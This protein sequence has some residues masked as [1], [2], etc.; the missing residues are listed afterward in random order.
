MG[1]AWN[2]SMTFV[3][4]IFFMGVTRCHSP[5]YVFSKYLGSFFR[6]YLA[7]IPTPCAPCNRESRCYK[8]SQP[9]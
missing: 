3:D 9:V 7:E 8:P 6:E 5:T 4:F 2:R 1:A